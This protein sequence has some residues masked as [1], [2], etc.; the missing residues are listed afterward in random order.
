MIEEK[1][2]RAI[3]KIN[4]NIFGDLEDILKSLNKRFNLKI[5]SILFDEEEKYQ[6]SL[7]VRNTLAKDIKVN[8]EELPSLDSIF[9][10]LNLEN[11]NFPKVED[12]GTHFI[13]EIKG[14]LDKRE[15]V[16]E[17]ND[18]SVKE[19]KELELA[20]EEICATKNEP[21][22]LDYQVVYSNY[23]KIGI[24][25]KRY[26]I[27]YI[28]E[29]RNV[30][31]EIIDLFYKNPQYSFLRMVLD[32]FFYDYYELKELLLISS[33]QIKDINKKYNEKAITFIRRMSRVFFGKI[34]GILQEGIK[35]N[36]ENIN[37]KDEEGGE[38]GTLEIFDNSIDNKYYISNLF[39][40]IDDISNKTYEGANPFGSILF[41]S[42][43]F[44]YENT[45]KIRYAV[46]FNEKD[47]IKLGDSKRIRKLLEI[48][49]C[50][51]E[52]YLIANYYEV[53]GIGEVG[54][55]DLIDD[56]A[57]I[58]L[59]FKGLSKYNLLYVHTK[60]KDYT[61]GKLVVEEEKKIYKC[62]K[63][64][65]VLEDSL[66]TILFKNPK[67]K[68]EEY[69]T[70]KFKRIFE[71]EFG[72]KGND[73]KSDLNNALEK[74][75]KVVKSAKEQKHGTMVVIAE[76]ETAKKELHAL[77]A[78][79]TLIVPKEID[80]EY[81]KYLTAIDGAI[82]FDTKGMCHA[83]GVIL[84]G[85]AN[86]KIGDP[87]R[88]A[89]YNSAYKYIEKLKSGDRNEKCMI[90]IISE[91]GMVDIIPDLENEKEI[92]NIVQEII[93]LISEEDLEN[94]NKLNDYEQKLKNYKKAIKHYL[95]FEIAEEFC[96]KDKYEKAIEYYEMGF[97]KA[98]EENNSIII[99]RHYNLCGDCYYCLK[100]EDAYKKSI[101]LYGKAAK[102]NNNSMDSIKFFSNIG[103]AYFS[104][105]DLYR[106]TNKSEAM[107][108]YDKVIE[109][110]TKNIGICKENNFEIESS[111]YNRIGIC[112]HYMWR[113]E[114]NEKIKNDYFRKAI[115]EYKKAISI[116][117]ESVYY[118]NRALLYVEQSL[119]KEALEG[120][121]DSFI[122]DN[123]RVENID[124]IKIILEKNNELAKEAVEF[125]TT[126][127]KD[128]KKEIV[129]N[130]QK[131]LEEY[132]V[133]VNNGENTSTAE[134][135]EEK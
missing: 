11:N 59:D 108:C 93:Y 25:S 87:S 47:R 81:V 60:V 114:K 123:E 9:R 58:R 42:E 50:E 98:K 27:T 120:F 86:E 34:Q 107:E 127:C 128:N 129:D 119:Y 46:E 101:M 14:C 40:E 106:E 96:N 103:M 12:D 134:L 3:E 53:L 63:N 77:G 61:G 66:L 36:S 56:D 85:I 99:A 121:I 44:I 48:T 74:I 26:T 78:Q 69:S 1:Q 70:E 57:L 124:Q 10:E 76:L 80:A 7:R 65:E 4:E 24:D 89:R 94:G 117:K 67:I 122:L 15:T 64:L 131:V 54:W 88:G 22:N 45:N 104:L 35:S 31:K 92:Q 51:K 125:Y 19:F 28:I 55:N 112:N 90:V 52:L 72:R 21:Y 71:A 109:Y 116:D 38:K 73:D 32:N 135:V 130:L 29:I 126:Q 118:W 41:L 113:I 102:R 111:Y 105:G 23:L 33:S 20:V 83:I 37:I 30:D 49:N 95:Y 110:Y 115:E 5:Y 79:S 84:D 13:E 91:D 43:N 100:T 75:E 16:K 68:E 133:K 82:Y 132:V 2:K 17:K 39:E 6:Y 62:G 8:Q 97:D 18:V